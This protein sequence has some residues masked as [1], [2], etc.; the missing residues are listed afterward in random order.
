MLLAPFD[1]LRHPSREQPAI[2]WSASLP[3][4][5]ETHPR[6]GSETEP[7][8]APKNYLAAALAIWVSTASASA[9]VNSCVFTE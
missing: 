1:S 7:G 2:H 4:P 3:P 9:A 6:E 5:A 8:R